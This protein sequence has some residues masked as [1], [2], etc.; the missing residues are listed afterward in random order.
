V[1]LP[2]SQMTQL[3][4]MDTQDGSRITNAG[5]I[6]AEP[7]LRRTL[8]FVTMPGSV[9]EC[10]LYAIERELPWLVIEQVEHVQAAC[11]R[12]AHPV[13]LILID[14]MQV[15]AAEDAAADIARLHPLALTAVMEP[16]SHNPSCT[17]PEIFE[18]RLVR[19]V[20]PMDLKLDVWL[21]VIRLLLRG[22]EYFPTALFH[23]YAEK[24]VRASTARPAN[25]SVS[26]PAR[27]TNEDDLAELTSREIEI[28]EMVSRGLQNKAIA[29]ALGLSEHTVKIHLHNIIRK[30]GAHNRTEA[31]AR[32]HDY[33]KPS[34]RPR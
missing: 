32:F 24:F 17:F 13:S 28:L 21:S 26:S 3:I 16:D 8:L 11:A 20:L 25:G 19:G 23:S 15:K 22:G 27:N 14:P 29:A 31:A 10:L 33:R 6:E 30:L 9:A 7:G 18:S 12:F 2:M 34:S 5:R 1:V 4:K